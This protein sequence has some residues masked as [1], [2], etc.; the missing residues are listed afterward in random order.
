MSLFHS[1]IPEITLTAILFLLIAPVHACSGSETGEGSGKEFTPLER[2]DYERYGR[3]AGTGLR[4]AAKNR[5]I[6]YSELAEYLVERFDLAERKGIGI[7]LGSGPGDLILHLAGRT[8]QFYW[9]NA[10]INTRYVRPFASDILE[11]NIAYRTGFIFADAC[12]LPFRDNYADFV[13][14]RG[15]YQFWSDLKKGL[16]E[17]YRILHPGGEA[18]I[19]RGVSPT[20][21]ENEVKKLAAR[22]LIGGPKYDPDED[23][24]RFRTL[25]QA[26][27]IEKFEVI[28]HR[29]GDPVLNY[30]V[31][32]Y[33]QKAQE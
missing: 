21:P 28:R 32:L 2:P 31:W 33:F 9:I 11:K 22:Q 25:M 12:A 15:S 26:M 23:A 16:S 14:S 30:G 3:E 29:P 6:V 4:K 20:M 24:G 10:D 13:V 8:K 18:F 7:D 17:I 5:Q 19:G 27:N 1:R